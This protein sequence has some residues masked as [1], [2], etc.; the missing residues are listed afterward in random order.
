M[1]ENIIELR[2][3]GGESKRF[4]GCKDSSKITP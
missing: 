4:S 1:N 3:V 2:E